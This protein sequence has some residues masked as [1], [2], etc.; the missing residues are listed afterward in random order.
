MCIYIYIKFL[1]QLIFNY[2][3]VHF[4]RVLLEISSEFKIQIF[5]KKMSLN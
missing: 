1:N 5:I 2:E 4:L 3:K